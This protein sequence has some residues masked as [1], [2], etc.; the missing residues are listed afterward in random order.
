MRPLKRTTDYSNEFYI[1]RIWSLRYACYETTMSSTTITS[2]II[3]I[4]ASA[5]YMMVKSILS[6]KYR[7][8][9]SY[10]I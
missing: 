7:T 1:I 2:T 8:L 9:Y 10:N 4:S 3:L 6:R 5:R